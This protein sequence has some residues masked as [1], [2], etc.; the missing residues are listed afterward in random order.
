MVLKIDL[1]VLIYRNCYLDSVSWM[2]GPKKHFE[3]SISRK[4]RTLPI[5]SE[6]FFPVGFG[7]KHVDTQN[8]NLPGF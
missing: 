5:S 8:H 1:Y 4:C 7:T 6:L 2:C 3:D